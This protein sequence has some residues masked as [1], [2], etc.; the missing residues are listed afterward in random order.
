MVGAFVFSVFFN[1]NTQMRNGKIL[2]RLDDT[3]SIE[4]ITSPW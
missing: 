2:D 4:T 3:K 1:G